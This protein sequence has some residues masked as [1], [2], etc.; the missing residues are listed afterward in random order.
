MRNLADVI[1]A[2][3]SLGWLVLGAVIAFAL[4]SIMNTR[5]DELSKVSIGPTGF[6]V[7]FVSNKLDEASK[8]AAAPSP[9]PLDKSVLAERLHSHRD[10]VH[11]SQLLWVDDH[12]ENNRAIVELL[13]TFGVDVEI[14]LSNAE[15]YLLLTRHP[16][17]FQVLISDVG[18][19]DEAVAGEYP[20]A[21]FSS[22]AL[23]LTGIRTILFVGRFRPT[24]VPGLNA[25]EAILLADS[26]DRATFGT[27]NRPDEL[28]HLIIDL[29]ERSPRRSS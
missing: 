17:R 22:R 12:P 6:T 18:R 28:V 26:I 11:G 14:A 19:V 27:T 3:T 2:L 7:E 25:D 8:D 21:E 4:R 1:S 20:G 29:L 15:A 9:G 13:T 5:R 23:E 10:L 16:H 24:S